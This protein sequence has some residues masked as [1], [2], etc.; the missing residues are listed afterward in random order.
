[1]SEELIYVVEKGTYGDHDLQL[2]ASLDAAIF[3]AACLMLTDANASWQLH[4]SP[5]C[6]FHAENARDYVTISSLPLKR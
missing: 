5:E 3:A 6:L 4:K 1:M 2:F